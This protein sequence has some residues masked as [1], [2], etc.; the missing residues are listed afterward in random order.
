MEH[1]DKLM[2]LLEV[3]AVVNNLKFNKPKRSNLSNDNY[4]KLL[5]KDH[6][7]YFNKCWQVLE[8]LS[9]KTLDGSYDKEY[10][11]YLKSKSFQL[12]NL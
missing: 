6:P 2:E 7:T 12:L 4:Y 1:K 9:T 3:H 5:A 10:L 8:L 11:D